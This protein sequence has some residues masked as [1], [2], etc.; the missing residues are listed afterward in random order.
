VASGGERPTT[1]R[2]QLGEA[3]LLGGVGALVGTP[4]VYRIRAAG[5]DVHL[6]R[7]WLWP[8]WWMLVPL[9]VAL[10]GALLMLAPRSFDLRRTLL[11]RTSNSR[12]RGS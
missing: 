4:V 9:L 12:R 8:T 6:A 10:I 5:S 1:P 11:R 3:L 2:R 7:N